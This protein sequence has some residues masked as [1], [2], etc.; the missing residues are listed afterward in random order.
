MIDYIIETKKTSQINS[1]HQINAHPSKPKHTIADL[2]VRS[3]FH[4]SQSN[5]E[6]RDVIDYI[7]KQNIM[8]NKY[9]V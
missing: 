3:H 7:K 4:L 2:P 8:T 9:V 5:L 1:S 6:S